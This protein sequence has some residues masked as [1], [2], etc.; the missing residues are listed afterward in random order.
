MPTYDYACR[1]CPN[2]FE[3][4]QPISEDPLQQCPSCNAPLL[5]RKISGGAGVVFKGTGFYETDYKR[6]RKK[7]DPSE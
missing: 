5:Y 3:H 2:E 7:E 1:G 4:R 6:P